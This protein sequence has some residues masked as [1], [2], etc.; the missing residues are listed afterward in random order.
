MSGRSEPKEEAQVVPKK[1]VFS[2]PGWLSLGKPDT[3][4]LLR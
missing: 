2:Y 3:L 1:V 4:L